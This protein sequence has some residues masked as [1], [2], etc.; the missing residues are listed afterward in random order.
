MFH[1]KYLRIVFQTISLACL[2]AC[3]SMHVE[4]FPE[5][6]QEIPAF[7]KEPVQ[8]IWNT[9]S[10]NGISDEEQKEI[11]KLMNEELTS[12]AQSVGND[13]QFIAMVR[14]VET[15]KPWLNWTS[16]ILV[17]IPVDRG[18]IAVDFVAKDVST[19]N[20]RVIQFAEWTPLTDLRAQYSQG[21]IALC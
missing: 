15:V 17:I 9:E 11:T 1:K 8:V 20:S 10:R 3:S 2:M 14:R 12:F 6:Q 5:N 16:T 7:T 4:K 18:G 19:G 13:W 21:G